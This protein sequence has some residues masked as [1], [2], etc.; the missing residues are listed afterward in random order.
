MAI[1][2][3]YGRKINSNC[4]CQQLGDRSDWRLFYKTGLAQM[5]I[6]GG[7]MCMCRFEV[8]LKAF[9]TSGNFGTQWGTPDV[10]RDNFI[11]RH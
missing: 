11:C 7:K 6:E 10:P 1:G 9:Y 4:I 2:T 3:D 8:L 5:Y